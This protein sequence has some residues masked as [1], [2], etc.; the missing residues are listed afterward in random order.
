MTQEEIHDE[1]EL[2]YKAIQISK[3][4]LDELRKICKHP[5]TSKTLY[6]WRIGSTSR[7]LV[8]VDCGEVV[9]NLDMEIFNTE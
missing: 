3:D 9:K 4:R 8:C 7:V 2:C 1:C 6:E 5:N